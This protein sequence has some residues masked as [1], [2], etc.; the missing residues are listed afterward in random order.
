MGKL[1]LS[2]IGSKN[3][4]I[5]SAVL[6]IF[7]STRKP[8][9][10]KDILKKLTISA[11]EATV[12]RVVHFFVEQ[13]MVIPVL[14]QKNTTCYELASHTHHHHIVCVSC[15]DIEDFEN[16]SLEKMLSTVTNNAEKFRVISTH[17]LEFFGTCISC[18]G[19]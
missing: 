8:L 1:T 17:S 15:G 19:K 9:S 4:P 18:Q 11:D 6:D 14:L 2:S 5:R 10:I 16:V 12:Y 7:E 13:K 3:T